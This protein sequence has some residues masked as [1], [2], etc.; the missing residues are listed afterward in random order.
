VNVHLRPSEI[1]RAIPHEVAEL[2]RSFA[3]NGYRAWVVGGCLRDLLLGRAA[4]DWDLATDARPEQ[5]RRI[6]PKVLPTGL[7]HGTVTI[8]HRGRGY[9]VTTLRG[10]GA[11]SD[12]RRPDSVSFVTDIAQ[13]LARRDF[14]IN[15]MAYDPLRHALEDPHGGTADLARGVI[16]A[17]GAP[18]Q[19]FAEDGLRV[20]RAARF[21]ATLEF[22]LEPATQAAIAG[23]LDTFRRVSA[24]RVRDEW[25]KALRAPAA[26]RAFA[27]MAQSGILEVSYPELAALEPGLWARS[28]R[29]LDVSAG[30]DPIVRLAALLW[31][32]ADTASVNAWLERYRYSNRE[33]ARVL[34]LLAHASAAPDPARSDAQLRRT[35][36]A[37]GREQLAD[38]LALSA[39]LAEAHF[40][41]HAPERAAAEQVRAR[42]AAL[43]QPHT[44][45][46]QR[47]LA[48]SGKDLMAALALPPGPKLG[49]LLDALLEAV[50]DDPRQNQAERLLE[51]AK[52]R[53]RGP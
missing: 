37:I 5:V 12:G 16:R 26:A 13:D 22:E 17:V 2:C 21:C 19:R 11:Y 3:D 48:V 18:E 45:L 24:E 36:R 53:L 6:F 15:A 49:E 4:Q 8:R 20:L 29:A 52:E 32:L 34:L 28:L 50:L 27:V 42:M 47:E 33:R 1:Q 38:V 51:L 40:G 35:A 30:A 41:A 14:T 10:E 31:P 43:V 44:P 7:Q 46:T 39:V 25:L 9:E 23:T